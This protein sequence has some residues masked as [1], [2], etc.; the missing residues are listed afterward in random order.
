MKKTLNFSHEILKNYKNYGIEDIEVIVSESFNLSVKSRNL[1]LENIEKSKNIN[2]GINIYREKRKATLTLNNI[3]NNDTKKI[4]EKGSAMVKSMPIDKYSGLPDEKYYE[5][6][7][8]NLDLEDRSSITDDKLFNE[9]Y[10][11]EEAMLANNKV[12]NTEGATRS[13]S[14]NTYSI[15]NSKGFDA[16]FTKTSHSIS[17]IAIAGADTNM[18]RDYEYDMATHANDLMAPNEIG[19]DAARRA[20]SRINSK[21]IKSCSLDVVLEPRVAKS[22]LS[23]FC[24]CA[25]GAA[26]ARGTSFLNKKLG[27]K[28]FKNNIIIKN[29][30]KLKR[31]IGSKPYDN[32]GVRNNNINIIKDGV[33]ANYFMNVRSA[34]QLN[35]PINGNSSPSNLILEKGEENLD[36]LL[37]N[38]NNGFL[39][40]EML[41]MS[42]NPINGDY[43]RGAAG[44]KIENGEV[45]YPVSEV[46]IAGNMI[47]ML[48]NLTPAN[49]L[50]IN[51]NINCPSILIEGMTLA[52]L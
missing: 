27:S 3:E 19:E 11:A 18:Q 34:R 7:I 32:N 26:I 46:T 16:S 21:K 8:Q 45:T 22:I 36:S 30:P 37:K 49:D 41:G 48:M 47:K 2:I 20:T 50:K 25:S 31:G 5:N 15:L 4:L 9:A 52:G 39:V 28:V 17:A 12:T 29:N 33:L 43:S 13:I 40:T 10:V 14:K 35:M 23:S 24:S 44:F 6:N 38:I 42:F 51:G 1:K